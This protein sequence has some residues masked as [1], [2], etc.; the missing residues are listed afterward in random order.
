MTIIGRLSVCS[1][2]AL[3]LAAAPAAAGGINVDVLFN[4]NPYDDLQVGLHLTNLAYPQPRE[5]VVAVFHEIQN[6]YEDYPVLAFIAHHAH[7]TPDIV[8]GYKK[9]GH[10]WSNVMLH[11][12]VH[13]NVLFMALPQP[14]R[15]PYGN[16]YGYWR[17]H[18]DRMPA[19]Q[20]TNE[21]IRFWVGMHALTAYTGAEPARVYEW[22]QT[23]RRFSQVAGAKY[24]EKH[25]KGPRTSQAGVDGPGKGKGKGHDWN[26]D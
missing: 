11:F 20:I 7:V 10:K 8:W 4:P 18:G 24:R 2:V 12:G 5:R 21:D 26:R 3:L 25:G 13:P 16:A 14:P 15:P 17:K 19:D 22:N 6:P 23:G 9:K 1:A